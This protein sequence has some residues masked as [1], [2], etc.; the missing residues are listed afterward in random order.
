MATTFIKGQEV[1]LNFAIPQGHVNALRM[2]EDGEFFYLV[3]WT[4]ADGKKKLRWFKE[5]ELI[6]VA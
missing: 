2:N 3:N 6:A 5:N 1:K 4:D